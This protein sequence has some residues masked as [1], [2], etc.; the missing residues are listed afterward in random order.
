MCVRLLHNIIQLHKN[1]V[2]FIVFHKIFPDIF[3]VQTECGE[4]PGLLCE[5][6]LA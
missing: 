5:I 3:H 4:Y 6:Q 2:G 1:Y